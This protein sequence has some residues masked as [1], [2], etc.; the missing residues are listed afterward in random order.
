MAY[1]K[2]YAYIDGGSMASGTLDELG[3]AALDRKRIG[4]VTHVERFITRYIPEL[5]Y[6]TQPS[7]PS[8]IDRD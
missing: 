1:T 2:D 5:R 8:S 4:L 7:S 6:T 3:L